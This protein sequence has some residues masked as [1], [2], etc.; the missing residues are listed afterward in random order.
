[1]KKRGIKSIQLYCVDNI[2]VKVGDPVFMGYCLAKG[3]ECANKV[4]FINLQW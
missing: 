2:L 3:A 1:M 4:I